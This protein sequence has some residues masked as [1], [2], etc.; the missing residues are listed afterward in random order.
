MLRLDRY[1]AKGTRTEL[2][3]DGVTVVLIHPGH[4]KTDMGGANA[5][6]TPEASA[7][8]IINVIDA[9]TIETT[10]TFMKWNGEPHNW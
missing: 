5:E 6:I 2:A 3:Q 1:C 8:G 10:G 7:E 4:V 9:V